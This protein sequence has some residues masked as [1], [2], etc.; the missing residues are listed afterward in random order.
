L[1]L[2]LKLEELEEKYKIRLVY[3]MLLNKPLHMKLQFKWI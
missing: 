3:K 2:I 1:L